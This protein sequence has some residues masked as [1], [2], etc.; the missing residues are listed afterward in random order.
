M[1]QPVTN[2]KYSISCIIQEKLTRLTHPKC[3]ERHARLA[4]IITKLYYK[5]II[6][7]HYITLQTEW[8]RW[9]IIFIIAILSP[10]LGCVITFC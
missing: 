5:Y 8:T 1:T 3:D 10:F 7:Y 2:K 6:K 4:A 9:V